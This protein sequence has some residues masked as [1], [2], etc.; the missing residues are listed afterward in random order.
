MKLLFWLLLILAVAIGISLL[1][2]NNDGYVLI[3]HPPYRLELSFNLLVL[4]LIGGFVLLHAGLR[5]IDYTLHLPASVRAYKQEQHR[6]EG[7]AA[8]L[9]A[10][11]A[12]VEGRYS[13][14]EKAAARALELGEDAGLTA[15]V[16]A[17][18]S[19]KLRQP[20]SRDYYLAEAERRNSGFRRRRLLRW[21]ETA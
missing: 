14:A 3:V 5:L 9:E 7:H 15:L 10:L 19:H 12:L 4:L 16:A 6:K 20:G 11:H 1:A 18:A 17:R 2:G 8:L 21:E 13:K